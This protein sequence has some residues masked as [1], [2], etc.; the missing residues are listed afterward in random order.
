MSGYCVIYA[1]CS[2]EKQARDG[3]SIPTQILE[4]EKRAKE[5]KLKIKGIFL[6]EG[7]SAKNAGVRGEM[8]KALAMLSKGDIFLVYSLSRTARTDE[9]K[10]YVKKELKDKHATVMAIQEN[11]D[12]PLYG[13]FIMDISSSVYKQEIKNTAQ[14]VKSG[15]KTKKERDGTCNFKAKYGYRYDK[16]KRDETGKYVTTP[17]LYE[18]QVIKEIKALR[19]K[20]DDRPDAKSHKAPT[21]YHVIATYLNTK[22]HTRMKNKKTGEYRK[23][24]SSTVSKI[25]EHEKDIDTDKILEGLSEE[26]PV[27]KDIVTGSIYLIVK[28]DFKYI[29]SASSPIDIFNKEKTKKFKI[30]IYPCELREISYTLFTKWLQ[31]NK[32][33]DPEA[34]EEMILPSIDINRILDRMKEITEK[35]PIIT[36]ISDIPT[37]FPQNL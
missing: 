29:G 8:D 33:V 23:W 22:Y 26:E 32:Y 25:Y 14:R 31:G 9:D 3:L 7:R 35:D 17:V 15:M 13:E 28:N 5:R 11:T 18:Q 30:Y 2:T 16:T 36:T 21:P 12:D 6:D 34:N 20:T 37:L 19:S 27:K 24:H 1:R 4:C 10:L